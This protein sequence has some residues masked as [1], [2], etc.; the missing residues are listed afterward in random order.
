MVYEIPERVEGTSWRTW[1]G[2][3]TEEHARKER[4]QIRAELEI[5]KSKLNFPLNIL[6]LVSVQNV[7]EA[8]NLA[9]G[10]HDGLI[11]YANGGPVYNVSPYEALMDTEKLNI[12][13]VRYQSGPVS[14]Y[15]TGAH[16]RLLRQYTDELQPMGGLSIAYILV[17]DYDEI[18]WRLRA[19]QCLKS[20]RGKRIVCIGG[21]GGWGASS[22]AP[23]NARLLWDMDLVNVSYDN[24]DVRINAA[25]Q[26]KKL[27]KQI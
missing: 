18:L 9:S 12:L 3:I 2:L 22:I 11:I 21:A 7:E 26:D 6:P 10:N 23:E 24:Y 4:A 15:Y 25:F 13:F 20:I 19:F 5:M 14:Y 16:H 1:S 8:K 27:V 17:D